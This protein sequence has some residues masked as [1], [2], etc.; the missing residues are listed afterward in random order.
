MEFQPQHLTMKFNNII[1]YNFTIKIRNSPSI[2]S[3][4]NFVTAPHLQQT[5]TLVLYCALVQHFLQFSYKNK[6][7][8]CSIT[9][10]W[11][12]KYQVYLISQ[13][14]LNHKKQIIE[15][16]NIKIHDLLSRDVTELLVSKPK[17]EFDTSVTA[18]LLLKSK[19]VETVNNIKIKQN[20]SKRPLKLKPKNQKAFFSKNDQ[21]NYI[22]TKKQTKILQNTFIQH[23]I[24]AL[25]LII[26]CIHSQIQK[27][28]YVN[29]YIT[30]NCYAQHINAYIQHKSWS[31]IWT[32]CKSPN[33]MVQIKNCP[34]QSVLQYY[35]E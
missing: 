4:K 33:L 1:M 2:N 31:L 15:T 21:N 14:E 8:K 28:C 20:Q 13:Y 35:Y 26:F 9:I 25:F 10:T 17:P 22:Q 29:C 16:K 32:H 12:I 24:S 34:N 6:H 3:R 19:L 27:N 23:Q 7:Y 11:D 30:L 18:L 5:R